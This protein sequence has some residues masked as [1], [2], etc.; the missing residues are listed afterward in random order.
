ME[1]RNTPEAFASEEPLRA[2]VLDRLLDDAPTI[3]DEQPWQTGT[4]LER[5][6]E[7][8]CRDLGNLLNS[9]R[10][11]TDIPEQFRE[12]ETSLVN[13]GLPDL[14]SL[15]IRE[16][17]AAQQVSRLIGDTIRAFEPR[18]QGVHVVPAAAE[19]TDLSGNRRLRFEIEAVL[20]IEPLREPVLFTSAFDF[21]RGNFEI[22]GDQ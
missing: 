18:L 20:V 1:M 17:K 15:D 19:D 2:S 6:R 12:L 11:L 8:V 13:Y 16:G 3:S 14:Q 10:W 4:V 5:L 7:H 21:G 9:R 22:E